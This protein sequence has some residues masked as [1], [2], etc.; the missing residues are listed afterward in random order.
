VPQS[1]AEALAINKANGNTLWK[2]VIEKELGQILEYKTFKILPHGERAPA[3]HKRVPLHLVFD[4]KH[5]GQR[6]A[7][8]VAGGHVTDPGNEEVW[9]HL[10]ESD[11]S[12]S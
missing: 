3:D 8:L 4:V 6:K 9:S 1:V 11:S 7:C 12:C 2:D 10:K 5:D